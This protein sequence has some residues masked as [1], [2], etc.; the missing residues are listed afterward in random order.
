MLPEKPKTCQL[1]NSK[2]EPPSIRLLNVSVNGN[3]LSV[4]AYA[5][6]LYLAVNHSEQS[7]IGASA[8]VVSGVDVSSALSYKNIARE[9]ELT[10]RALNA[11]SF[12]LGVTTIF[13]GTHSLFMCEKLQT[14]LDQCFFLLFDYLDLD[15]VMILGNRRQ[16]LIQRR[17]KPYCG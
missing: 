14:Y 17:N 2:A 10:V 1:G 15:L 7:V 3:L 16:M 8:Y 4:A 5:L 13:G 6:K 9:H 11:K 12:G